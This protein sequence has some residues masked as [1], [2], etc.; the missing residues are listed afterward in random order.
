M[1]LID[2]STRRPVSIFI[3]SVAAVVFGVVAFTNLATDLLPDITYPSITVRT[4][5]DGAAPLEIENLI[6]RPIENAVGVVNNVV[7]VVSSSRADT[8]EVTLEFAWGTDMDLAALDVRERLDVL[9]LPVDAERPLLL[10]YDPSL[11]PIMRL[12]AY[13]EEDLVRLRL[14]AEEQIQRELERIEGVAAVVIS[15][16]LEEEILVELDERRIA[17]LGLS[18]AIVLDRLSAE[19]VDLT[20]GRLREGQTEYLVRTINEYVRPEDMR[21]IVV[22]ASQGA[23]VRLEDVATVRKGHKEREVVTRIGGHESVEVAVYKEGGT[24]TVAVS[25]A[26]KAQLAELGRRLRQID[27]ALE[28]RV[29]TDQAGYIRQSVSQVLETAVYG[30]FLAI[31]MLFLFLRSWKT[32]LIVGVAI[33]ISVVTTFFLMYVSGISLNIMS[34]GGLTLGIGMLVDNSIVVLEAIQRKRDDG[35]GELQ[36]AEAGADEVASAVVAS[37]LTTICVFVPIVFVEGIAGQL[38][39]DQALTVTYSLSVSLIVALTL[40]PMLASRSFRPADPDADDERAARGA[41]GRA[42]FG[43]AVALARITGGLARGLAAVTSALS[44][45]PLRLFHA[46]YDRLAE[47]YRRSLDAVLAHPVP[48]V[49]VACALLFATLALYPRLGKELVPELV[50]GEFFV[51]IQLPPGTRLEVTERRIAA[52]ERFALAELFGVDALYAIAG[53]SNRQG[54]AAGERRE[55]IGQLTVTLVPPVDRAREDA[56]I[57]RL[58]Q[59]LEREP[60]IEYRFGRPSYFSFRTPIEVEI[61][62]YNLTLLDRLSRELVRR[63]GG[64][65]GL[66]DIESST[67][68]GNPELR[69]R[70]DRER[71]ASLGLSVSDVAGTVRTKVQGTVATD[72]QREDRQIDIR[73]RSAETFRDSV[74]DLLALTVYQRDKTAV[75]LSAVADVEE[76]EGPAEIRRVEGERVA[77]V[78]ANL[79]GRDLESVSREIGAA[80]ESMQL[81]GGYEW[82]IGGQRQEMQTSFGSMRLAIGLAI[83]MVY[84]VMASQFESLLHPFVILFSVPLA[85]IGVLLT[86]WAFRINISI[87]VLIGVILLAG[88]VVN[89]AIILLDHA[90]RLRRRDGLSKREALRRAGRVRLRPILMTTSTTVLGLL[91]MAVGIGAGSELRRP[92]ALVVIGGLLTSTALTLLVVPVV[93]DLLDRRRR[94]AP[95]SG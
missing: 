39:G 89:N 90:N 91:P 9:R 18:E 17:N 69:I 52:L 63:M 12:G 46:G 82:R 51:D 14:I 57:E 25:D 68:G 58:R 30:G 75:P 95:S 93:Y 38:F 19:N 55:N 85:L 21:S 73:M 40:I 70:F 34:L 8:S 67:E 66:S 50:Q 37:T 64:I 11:D 1:K 86:L 81:P 2:F 33:P 65:D 45:V 29:I 44:R 35:L 60:A 10:R 59:A 6:T 87:V 61:R 36:A 27:P 16:G 88:I 54:G 56:M 22:D 79:V 77:V 94:L 23:I 26:V 5:Y 84:L 3:Y 31:L 28:L 41:I 74:D 4:D 83:F 62:G 78:S 76:V 92:M 13:G 71:L 42:L 80:L 53:T 24:N 43:A 7:R 48:T 47:S 49:A 32:T 15:G 72:I 20:G